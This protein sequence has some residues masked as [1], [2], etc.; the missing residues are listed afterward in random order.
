MLKNH[1]IAMDGSKKLAADIIVYLLSCF[2]YWSLQLARMLWIGVLIES[3]CETTTVLVIEC[4]GIDH[5]RYEQVENMRFTKEKS[6]V[7]VSYVLLDSPLVIVTATPIQTSYWT[8]YNN[9]LY[10]RLVLWKLISET[11]FDCN[12]SARLCCNHAAYESN[13]GYLLLWILH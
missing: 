13:A 8:I 1:A 5:S 12:H 10:I 11:Q 4:H 7:C 6:A 2:T 9:R 3:Y